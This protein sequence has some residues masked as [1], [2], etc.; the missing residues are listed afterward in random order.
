MILISTLARLGQAGTPS[1]SAAPLEELATVG[2]C[3]WC[4]RINH[5]LYRDVC[6]SCAPAAWREGFAG[7]LERTPRAERELRWPWLSD[8]PSVLRLVSVDRPADVQDAMGII[9]SGGLADPAKLRDEAVEL[10]SLG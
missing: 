5:V 8:G 6:Y 10:V 7:I 3:V 9:R 2:E 4:G 1:P